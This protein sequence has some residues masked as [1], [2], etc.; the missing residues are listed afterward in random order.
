M[1][2]LVL[3]TAAF[4]L[5]AGIAQAQTA[6]TTSGD[7]STNINW[8]S[9]LPTLLNTGT[10]GSGIVANR[11][12]AVNID[13][14]YIIIANGGQLINPTGN[15][16]AREMLGASII[17]VQT[18][19]S[20]VRTNSGSTTSMRISGNSTIKVTGGDV[21][22]DGLV[23]FN[24]GAAGFTLDVS[25]G[26]FVGKKSLNFAKPNPTGASYINISGGSVQMGVVSANNRSINNENI[27]INLSGGSLE[28]QDWSPNNA[29]ANATNI[30]IT[31]SNDGTLTTHNFDRENTATAAEGHFIDL[32]GEEGASWT[33]TGKTSTNF[34]TYWNSGVLQHDGE[35]T[36]TFAENFTVSGDTL[37]VIPEPATLGM[38]AIF[39]GF[40]FFTRRR[41][42]F[43]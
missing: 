1:K 41:I 2:K 14:Q 27:F 11:D 6:M 43:F 24:N 15:F 39:G 20:Y 19:G 5:L 12:A 4:A 3:A 21:I 42:R 22:M 9:G 8:S 28:L 25:A 16:G 35:N 33:W 18:G 34:E 37:T 36:G 38:V 30:T 29:D 23:G 32:L 31:I 26:T 10:I 17:E 7:I 40:I 13:G